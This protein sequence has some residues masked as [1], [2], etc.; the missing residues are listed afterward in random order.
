MAK[1]IQAVIVGNLED[2][3]ALQQSGF[4]FRAKMII[5]TST[6]LIQKLTREGHDVINLW[7]YLDDEAVE[8]SE[9][10]TVWLT[11]EFCIAQESPEFLKVPYFETTKVYMRY[12]FKAV[13]HTIY[14][15]K[16]LL[17]EYE[18]SE[19]TVRAKKTAPLNVAFYEKSHILDGVAEY[20]AVR[21]NI[22]VTYFDVTPVAATQQ[23]HALQFDPADFPFV[24]PDAKSDSQKPTVLFVLSQNFEGDFDLVRYLQKSGKLNIVIVWRLEPMQTRNTPGEK[25][26]PLFFSDFA[27]DDDLLKAEKAKI[28]SLREQFFKSDAFKNTKPEEIF[29]NEHLTF[30]FQDLFKR[31]EVYVADVRTFDRVFK[32]IQPDAV[33]FSNS[34]DMSV[35]CMI[36]RAQ[37]LG[38]ETFVTQHGGVADTA[39]YITRQL[40]VDNYVVWG[41]DNTEGLIAAGQEP[42]TIQ[43][44]GSIQM[45]FW[46]QKVDSFFGSEKSSEHEE[47][48]SFFDDNFK[49][50]AQD[51][52][53]TV[54][55]FT[56]AG[57]GFSGHS[58]HEFHHLDTLRDI[59]LLANRFPH[60][61]FR[62]KPHVLFDYDEFWKQ[63]ASEEIPKN[64]EII[65][66][67][68]LLKA[69][70][71][72]DIAVLV[73]TISN[74]AYEI[75]IAG[76]PVVFLKEGCFKVECGLSTLERGGILCLDS[77]AEFEQ[78]LKEYGSNPD[79]KLELEER[80]RQ[81]LKHALEPLTESVFKRIEGLFLK[82]KKRE[83]SARNSDIYSVIHWV[84]RSFLKEPVRFPEISHPQSLP[85]GGEL[86]AWLYRITS[87]RA[88]LYDN[89][90]PASVF[91]GILRQVPASYGISTMEKA[92]RT[93]YAI[94]R[95]YYLHFNLN[96]NRLVRSILQK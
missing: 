70:L 32:F 59:T 45:D 64:I 83:I 69:C 49:E 42:E 11:N 56:S 58:I 34:W 79:L 61:Q 4:D 65:P 28:N 14:V 37:E 41:R 6:E 27:F 22:P 30:Q 73:N 15:L 2:Y 62:I 24:M 39:G 54:T 68:D 44:V 72:T 29:K 9:Q 48:A 40:K 12:F 87:Q 60:I 16:R 19:I 95:K 77:V 84:E 43:P 5:T 25:N 96:E 86:L 20:I 35:R 7:K 75:S 33:Y 90:D 23:P 91:L 76:K 52:P 53:F 31:L 3:A 71:E 88:Y 67:R 94:A 21:N 10:E 51:R 50:I 66:K 63:Y 26:T 8:L 82:V 92:K 89:M 1:R 18:I 36:C 47:Y 38:A 80:R 78:F 55:Y 74:V 57:G 17:G 85:S 13:Y 81:F 93:I 46:K